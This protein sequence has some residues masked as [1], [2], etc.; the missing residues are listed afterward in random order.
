MEPRSS[1]R[2]LG[3]R[4]K[5]DLYHEYLMGM[6]CLHRARTPMEFYQELP[7]FLGTFG[8]PGARASGRLIVENDFIL[9]PDAYRFRHNWDTS[10]L[11]WRVQV[12][13]AIRPERPW[14]LVVAEETGPEVYFL[15]AN[16]DGSGLTYLAQALCTAVERFCSDK[17][18]RYGLVV[19]AALRRPEWELTLDER[20]THHERIKMLTRVESLVHEMDGDP[21]VLKELCEPD[22][23][24]VVDEILEVRKH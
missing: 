5:T 11:A 1:E 10:G 15:D 23:A 17:K 22:V 6:K 21:L 4:T 24:R 14:I 20:L 7:G 3:K 2:S 12:H 9:G 8:A 18:G 16:G 19:G 13:E